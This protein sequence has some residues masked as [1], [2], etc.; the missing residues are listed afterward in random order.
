MCLSIVNDIW[1]IAC[2]LL[3]SSIFK[4]ST[5]GMRM[6]RTA[7]PCLA[8]IRESMW[9]NFF[10]HYFRGPRNNPL[11]EGFDITGRITVFDEFEERPKFLLR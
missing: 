1:M 3:K 11:A 9:D 7:S 4:R 5:R 2:G 8:L 10:G 6:A